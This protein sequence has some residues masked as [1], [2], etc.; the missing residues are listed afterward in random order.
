MTQ[1]RISVAV[2]GLARKMPSLA[3]NQGLTAGSESHAE[4]APQR[5]TENKGET[6]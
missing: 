1:C 3:P 4:E 2:R 6:Q 5:K